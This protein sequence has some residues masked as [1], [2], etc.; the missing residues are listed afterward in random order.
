MDEESVN[1]MRMPDGERQMLCP[2]TM[3]QGQ[4]PATAHGLA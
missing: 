1:Y 2:V 4:A 3:E